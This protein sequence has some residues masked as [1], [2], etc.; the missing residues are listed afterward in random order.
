MASAGGRETLA[1]AMKRLAFALCC[2]VLLPAAAAAAELP[3]A[4]TPPPPF[5]HILEQAPTL[6][7]IAPGIE[8]GDYRLFTAAGPLVVHVVDVQLKNPDVKI[9]SVLADN[10]LESRGETIG[11]MAKR[12]GAVA[13]INGDYFDIGNTN[14]PLNIVVRN[15]RLLAMPTKRYALAISRDGTARITQFSFYGQVQVGDRTVSLDSIDGLP[16]PNGGTALLTPA[17]GRV[18]P[19]ENVTL[20]ALQLLGG[21]PP[22]ARYRVTRIA[23]NLSTQPA[24]YYL[25]VGPSDYNQISVPNPGDV[26]EA[27]GD[28]S[29]IGLDMLT[30]AVG[31][32][33]MILRDGVWN[34]D[35]NGP[36]GGEFKRR[37]PCS[38]AAVT[39]NGDLLLIE[40]DGREPLVS[41]G[42]KR[43]EFAALMR[44]LG[45]TDGMALDGGG[46]S[47]MTVRLLGDGT[48]SVVNDPSDGRE[49]RVADGIFV[50][51]TA[52]VG[53]A[54]RLVARPG[55]IRAVTG[56][57][58]PLRVAA[59]DAA[60][61]V[62]SIDMPIRATVEPSSLGIFR[63]G[64]FTALQAGEGRIALRSGRVTGSIGVEVL[65]TPA[66]VGIVPL[67]PNVER[68]SSLTLLARAFDAHG[69]PL[70]LPPL[71]AWKTSAG[72]IDAKG[73]F[74]SGT[75]NA[76]VRVRI[77]EA[78]AF[79]RV[80][81]GS[82][83]VALPFVRDARFVTLPHGGSGSLEED[84][85]CEGC[86]ALT[87]AFSGN[88]RAAYAMANLPLPAQTIGLSFD[89]FDDGSGSRLRVALRNA[90]NED[91]LLHGTHLDRP[92]WRHVVVRWA[93]ASSEARRLL[94]I[95][96][97][98]GKG[99]ELSAGRVVL[100][101]VR[102]IVAGQ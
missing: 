55:V 69:Y 88:E 63:N 17:Y 67:Q 73:V 11:S 26:V 98:P 58:V 76:D 41:V 23:D 30:A 18:P 34:D 93:L 75:R 4:L 38:G 89:V 91:V 21:T 42:L 59:V 68:N 100:K 33:P 102:A 36:A 83:E 3:L 72:S 86:L 32:G 47:T 74:R 65:S 95:Y 80:T 84:P 31:G 1:G 24:G 19:Q 52:P 71:L 66:R 20:I 53:E 6:E 29:P 39:P 60:G 94:A 78:V 79:A 62:A 90:I 13:G 50:Y 15:G 45:A 9:A 37:I 35:P 44:G 48:A 61:H 12:T 82:H 7:S 51:S 14:R 64:R 27:S 56:A 97:L 101:N 16:A 2:F 22:L 8:Y 28:L 57:D 77:G 5:P 54:V 70:T 25:A 10:A 85:Q 46:S 49:R 96:V 99:M 81:V 40:V 87:Y 43:P 92:G